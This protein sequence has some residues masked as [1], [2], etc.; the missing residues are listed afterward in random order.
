MIEQVAA[1]IRS[2]H[3]EEAISKKKGSAQF[4]FLCTISKIEFP[5]EESQ[6]A[7]NCARNNM[8]INYIVANDGAQEAE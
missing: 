5:Y 3:C 1:E 8:Q 7:L 6:S 2:A 4:P